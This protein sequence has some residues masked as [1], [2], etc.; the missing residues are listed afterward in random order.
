MLRLSGAKLQLAVAAALLASTAALNLQHLAGAMRNGDEIIYAEM[1]REMAEGGDLVTLRWQGQPQLVRPPGAVWPLALCARWFGSSEG[2]LRAVVA[3]ESALAVALM[4]LLGALRY[5]LATGLCAAGLLATAERWYFYARYIESEPLLIV[6]VVGALLCWELARRRPA[7][8]LGFALGLAGAVLTKPFVGLLPLLGPL[9]D[10]LERRP[11]DRRRTLLSIGLAMVLAAPWHLAALW[12]YRGAF[13]QAF[14]VANVVGRATHALHQTTT[15]GFYLKEL[16]RF[17]GPLVLVSV[18]GLAYTAWRRDLLLLV[19]TLGVLVPFSLAASRYDYY[20]LPAYPA[21]ALAA[22]R[23]VTG[24]L[25]RLKLVLAILLVATS[26]LLHVAPR[27]G[28][29]PYGDLEIRALGQT[30]EAVSLPG[31]VVL[32]VDQYPYSAR[33]YT[34]RHTV[35]VRLDRAFEPI[36]IL[37]GEVVRA[38]ELATVAARYPRWFAIVPR[39]H[40][41]R[42]GPIGA[43]H[44][45]SETS[46]Y[47]LLT[48]TEPPAALGP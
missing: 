26:F 21:L 39:Q 14:F 40:P 10:V 48:N 24:A 3:V 32:V 33:F 34:R 2:A 19:W 37:P 18:I 35:E 41:W 23:A 27:L 20:A 12:R 1:A 7:W 29:I 9:V 46:G 13:W 22:A 42:A 43:V 31:D 30:V 44:K 28:K 17:E 15:A 25:P 11:L 45:V 8:S 47:L 5:D 16:W 6:F 36:A 38:P 4:F